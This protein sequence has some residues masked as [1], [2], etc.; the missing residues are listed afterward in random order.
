MAV[1]ATPIFAQAP[2]HAAAN[3]TT[4]NT[5]RD[6]TGTIGTIFTAGT[7]GSTI[8]RVDVTAT[9]STTAGVVRLYVHNGSTVFLWKELLVGAITPSVSVSVYMRTV[10]ER[11]Y[12]PTTYSLR[13]STQIGESFNVEAV[14]WDY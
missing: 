11:L 9:G 5:N 14:G 8:E 3:I 13:A 6:G 2:R 12:L 7:N 1:T 4:A 10:R